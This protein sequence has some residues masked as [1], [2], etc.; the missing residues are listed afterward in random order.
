LGRRSSSS[1][2]KA[3]QRGCLLLGRR[4]SSS[5]SKAMQ[6]GCLLLGQR[7]HLARSAGCW[8]VPQNVPA[9]KTGGVGW[10]PCALRAAAAGDTIQALGVVIVMFAKSDIQLVRV[11][12][13]GQHHHQQRLV[14]QGRVIGC[15]C[16]LCSVCCS[17][18]AGSW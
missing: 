3:M 18:T 1:S 7:G 15:P 14:A 12:N 4:S 10:C 5:S 17:S 6:R 13:C 16:T 8:L 11:D 2:S 9:C